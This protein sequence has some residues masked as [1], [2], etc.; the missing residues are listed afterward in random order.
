MVIWK[1]SV[2]AEKNMHRLCGKSK[3]F[4]VKEYRARETKAVEDEAKKVFGWGNGGKI[5]CRFCSFQLLTFKMLPNMKLFR[6]YHE[7][8]LSLTLSLIHISEPTRPPLISRM[9]SSA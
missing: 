2:I 7:R 9:P 4:V 3:F 1:Q 8:L 5:I 6:K